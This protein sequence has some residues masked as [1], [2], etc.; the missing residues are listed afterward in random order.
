MNENKI[1]NLLLSL[2]Q[3]EG[4]EAPKQ[5]RVF[6]QEKKAFGDFS[7]NL[8]FMLDRNRNNPQAYA[9]HIVKA[10]KEENKNDHLFEK[11]EEQG[12]FINFFLPQRALSEAVATI[13]SQGTSFGKNST[14]K[15]ET[16][17]LEFVSANP[18]G[19]LTIAHGRQ[20]AFGEALA[21]ILTASG[22]TVT[23][24][25]YLNDCG[26]QMKLLGLS[27]KALHL[28]ATGI[29]YKIP[30]DGYHGDYMQEISQRLPHTNL[31]LSDEEYTTFA[32]KEIL[33]SITQD[34]KDFGVFFDSW[35]RESELR[36]EGKVEASIEEL[37][38]K[39]FSYESEGALWF[40]TTLFGDDKDRVLRKQDGSYTYLAPDI[41]YHA[42]KIGRGYNRLITILGPDHLGYISR[43]KA[44]VEVFGFSAENLNIL[45]VQL[46]TLYR[47]T[48]KIAMSTRAGDFL[49]LRQ[50]IDEV[51]S[52]AVKFFFLFRKADSHLDFDLELAKKESDENPVYYLQYAYVRALHILQ[53]AK[54]KKISLQTPPDLSLLNED[55]DIALIKKLTGFPSVIESA[56]SGLEVS[57]VSR[58]LLDLVG[59]FHSYYQ[60]SRVITDTIPLSQARLALIR[61]FLTVISNGMDLLGITKP[62][63]M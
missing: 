55:S 10:L 32:Q 28:R 23:K 61:A 42:E 5:F 22:A 50:L 25:Y 12:G 33:S 3:K 14:K 31:P 8:A 43:L 47:G 53:H 9:S 2:L 19:P 30:E 38:K 39:G 58:Y 60:K 15:D 54:E 37:S 16:I 51:G 62:A 1:R 48:E 57:L 35:R 27:L 13:L 18:T 36:R 46:T 56:S 7:T 45:T 34:L 6:R 17:L 26:R 63:E 29:E 41:A 49:S 59:L 40:R 21:R 4:I 52:N 44:A 20:A 11:I 24:E